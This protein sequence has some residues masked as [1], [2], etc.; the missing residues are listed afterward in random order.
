MQSNSTL[1]VQQLIMA[2]TIAN[3]PL[4]MFHSI[5]GWNAD[6]QTHKTQT[7]ILQSNII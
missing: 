7:K 2:G 3:S 4:Y 5:W 1:F 6:A